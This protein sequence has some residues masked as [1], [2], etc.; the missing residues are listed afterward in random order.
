[1]SYACPTLLLDD[2]ELFLKGA[3]NLGIL[4]SISVCSNKTKVIYSNYIEA[5]VNFGEQK[6]FSFALGLP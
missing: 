6:V 3:V 1:M 2:S 4:K 5:V